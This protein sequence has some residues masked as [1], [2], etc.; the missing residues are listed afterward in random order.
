MGMKRKFLLCSIIIVFCIF[1][2]CAP[3]SGKL[4]D[5]EQ[6]LELYQ[7]DESVVAPEWKDS[8]LAAPKEEGDLRIIQIS[9]PHYFSMSITDQGVLYQNAMA[10]AAGR[11][12][13]HIGEILDAF[14]EQVQEEEPDVLIVSGDLSMNGEKASHIDFSHYLQKFEDIGIPVLVIP[15]NHDINSTSAREIYD[16]GA[17]PTENV[18]PEEFEEIYQE[19]G[20][21]DAIY[22]DADTLS[23][24]A[25]I[26][27]N[28]W[29]IMLDASIYKDGNIKASGYLSKDTR[30]W[31]YDI[32][33]EAH[34]KGI[35]IFTVTHQ[36][37]LAHNE[38]F[39][40][41]YTI[42]DGA[43]MVEKLMDEGVVIN[44]SGHMHSMNI[45]DRRE[46]FYEVAMGSISVWPNLYGQLD[47]REDGTY[48]FTTHATEHEGNSYAYMLEST[49]QTLGNRMP[50]F[51]LQSEQLTIM[52]DFIVE[53]NVDYF[54]GK[55]KTLEEYES[56]AGYQLWQ[57]YGKGTMNLD[58]INSIAHQKRN[59]HT[60]IA[61]FRLTK[62][63]S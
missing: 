40:S 63:C 27:N 54:A 13:L 56:E 19:F 26:G 14:Y 30:Q 51:D 43:S 41:N 42:T 35:R 46:L 47:I 33:E 44:L 7:V 52:R 61:P 38:N 18:T 6:P 20:Y 23:Y 16:S 28:C 59:D 1:A 8:F 22:R 57:E 60:F 4:E 53:M 34:Q 55:T 17:I 32:V 29:V 11:D 36:N 58:Y 37:L 50:Q 25:D 5:T 2:G 10:K 12:A 21:K 9:D 45:A 39:V 49:R 31:A 15:G 62:P 24:V 48:S 3:Q